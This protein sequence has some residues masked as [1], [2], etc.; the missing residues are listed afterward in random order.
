[1]MTLSVKIK[2]G[3]NSRIVSNPFTICDLKN[4]SWHLLCRHGLPI[5]A[6][7]LQPRAKPTFRSLLITPLLSLSTNITGLQKVNVSPSSQ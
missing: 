1:M 6:F 3:R 7:Y 4:A 2:A 5:V